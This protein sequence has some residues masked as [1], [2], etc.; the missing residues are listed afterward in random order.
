[1]ANK[2]KNFSPEDQIKKIKLA[3][4]EF[5]KKV[6]EIRSKRDEKISAILKEIDNKQIDQIRK[7]INN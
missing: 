3:Y 7:E 2:K 4:R 1:M 6:S 5:N